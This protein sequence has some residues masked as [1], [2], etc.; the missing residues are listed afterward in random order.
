MRLY[1]LWL[2][3]LLLGLVS[4]ASASECTKRK[5]NRRIRVCCAGYTRVKNICKPYCP[6]GCE[7]GMCVKPKE[8][9]CN[10]GYK[11]LNDYR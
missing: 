4:F 7:N 3:L 9:A 11:K 6:R 2:L 1:N 5:G 8:C 10:R